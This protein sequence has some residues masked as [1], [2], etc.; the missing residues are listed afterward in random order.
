MRRKGGVPKAQQ[1]PGYLKVVQGHHYYLNIT[2]A[3]GSTIAQLVGLHS[4]RPIVY[5]S[6]KKPDKANVESITGSRLFTNFVTK[7]ARPPP[8][9]VSSNIS[10]ACAS[11]AQGVELPPDEGEQKASQEAQ[12]ADQ[13]E[14]EAA[15]LQSSAV[16]AH[17]RNSAVSTTHMPSGLGAVPPAI[18]HFLNDGGLTSSAHVGGAGTAIG[19]GLTSSAHILAQRNP[20][21][22]NP[23]A[24]TAS[25]FPSSLTGAV[26]LQQQQTQQIL[27]A[28]YQQQSQM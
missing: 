6:V 23:S 8:P 22:F 9:I 13:S 2:F 12:I 15:K 19:L 28:Q 7:Y 17:E 1:S 21:L 10:L 14:E 11:W 27:A 16:R 3:A 25:A 18:N 20:H 26:P 24:V 5:L 4:W